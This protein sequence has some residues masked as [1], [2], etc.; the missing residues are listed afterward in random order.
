MQPR[1]GLAHMIALIVHIAHRFPIHRQEIIH[2][3]A[4]GGHHIGQ[5]IGGNFIVKPG[6]NL[7]HR[8]LGTGLEPN[9]DQA[10]PDF[11]LQ[12]FQAPFLG[13]HRRKT[14]PI[15]DTAQPTVQI[16]GPT[17]I[18]ADHRF[19]TDPTRFGH[20]PRSTMPA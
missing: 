15:G 17:M 10:I 11:H 20:N 2:R 16:I 1:M 4:V 7:S 18:G 5:I 9:E 12:R 3:V 19:I 14:I 8:R 6:Q 13:L